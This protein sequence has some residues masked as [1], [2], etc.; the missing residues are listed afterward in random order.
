MLP[1]PPTPHS[2][3]TITLATSLSIIPCYAEARGDPINGQL[4]HA[5]VD[6]VMDYFWAFVMFVVVRHCCSTNILTIV[7]NHSWTFVM[8][9]FRHSYFTNISPCTMATKSTRK[10]HY[11]I[12]SKGTRSVMQ[13]ASFLVILLENPLH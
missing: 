11:L 9:V 8:C 3:P 10:Q 2:T 6:I 7:M 13:P 4:C 1:T 12:M 5:R